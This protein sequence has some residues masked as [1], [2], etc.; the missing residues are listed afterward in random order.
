MGFLDTLLGRTRPVRPNMDVLFTVPSAADT[1][2]AAL[3]FA[4]TGVGAVCFKA[5]EGSEHSLEEISA[6]LGL[7]STMDV[8]VTADEFGYTWVTCRQSTVD[9]PALVTALHAVNATLADAGFGSSLLCTVIGFRA[10]GT[11]LGLVHL[12]RRGT[13]YPFA[14]TSGRHRDTALELRVR[15]ALTGEVP[16]E[17]DLARWFPLWDSP[18]P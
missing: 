12:F 3:G 8:Q 6:L 5:A 17:P 13:V 2:R 14:P 16:V 15:A 4:P 7:E 18:V 10:K 1:L 11:R 9:I